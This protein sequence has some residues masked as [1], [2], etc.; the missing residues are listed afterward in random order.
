MEQFEEADK[1]IGWTSDLTPD[2]LSPYLSA[3][4]Q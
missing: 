2:V 1:P 3:V 4:G